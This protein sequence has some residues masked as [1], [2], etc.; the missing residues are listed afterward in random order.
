[1][2]TGANDQPL[3]GETKMT[4]TPPNEAAPVEPVMVQ[5]QAIAVP[6]S[7]PVSTTVTEEINGVPDEAT[8][9]KKKKPKK[10]REPPPPGETRA[11]RKKRKKVE[12]TAKK[13]EKLKLK[14]QMRA[15]KAEAL[16]VS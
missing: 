11:E 7:E 10:K 12:R 14:A 1:M 3:G 9:G 4:Y 16:A 6:A 5:N 8:S 2:G 15:A 13:A